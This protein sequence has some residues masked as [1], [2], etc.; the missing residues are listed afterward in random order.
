MDMK[1]VKIRDIAVI[2]PSGISY[3]QGEKKYIDTSSVDNNKIINFEDVTYEERPSRANMA[4]KEGYVLFA[5]AKDTRKVIRMDNNNCNNIYST[6]FFVLKPKENKIL[7]KYLYY[8]FN[9]NEVELLKDRLAQGATQVAIN[10]SILYDKFKIPLPEISIQKEILNKLIELEKIL[11]MLREQKNKVKILLNSV[12]EEEINKIK[13]NILLKNTVKVLYRYPTFYGFKYVD[14]GLPVLKISNMDKECKFNED[15]SA[16]DKI[17]LDINMKYPKTIVKEKDIV[18]EVR[19]TYIGRCA[20][21][22][23]ILEGGNISPNTI[24]ISFD[25]NKILPEFFWHYSFTEKWKKQVARITNYWKEKFGTIK[26]EE[27]EILKLPFIEKSKQQNVIVK[28]NKINRLYEQ[29][30]ND[31]LKH[32][33]LYQS[34]LAK[35]FNFERKISSSE[36]TQSKLKI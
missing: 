31:L 25:D 30:S 34:A 9:F 17:T 10:N 26:S 1:L 21:V 36:V 33:M 14:E 15:L 2:I 22:P 19:G 3:F 35:Y 11:D 8:Y 20:L 29:F 7:S 32:Q 18:M 24:R 27:I 6:G 12:R 28:L 23:K 5:K 16:Y 4:V 13:E